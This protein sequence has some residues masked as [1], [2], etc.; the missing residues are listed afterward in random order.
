MQIIEVKPGILVIDREGSTSNLAMVRTPDGVVLIDTTSNEEE[1]REVLRAA[2]VYPDDVFLLIITHADGDHIGGASLFDCKV[3]AHKYTAAKM[4]RME[5]IKA[6]QPLQTFEDEARIHV[7]GYRFELYHYGGHKPDMIVVWLPEQKVLFPGDLVF[8]GRY[9]WIQD[10]DIPAWIEAL[11]KLPGYGA[12]VI[13]P[14]HGK[15]CGDAEIHL[16]R[17]YIENTWKRTREHVIQGHSLE[18]TLA[19]PEYQR[20]NGW[21]REELFEQN[22]EIMY[23]L[24]FEEFG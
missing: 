20:P 24:L 10:G 19:D 2:R 7:G 15:L 17:E 9:P 12:E 5:K 23:E 1:M 6:S 14:G 22:I 21:D 16:L 11:K 3:V 4:E 18:D 8:T 13:L